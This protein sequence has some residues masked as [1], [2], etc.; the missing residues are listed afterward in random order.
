VLWRIFA[1]V[2]LI[3]LALGSWYLTRPQALTAR[4]ARPKPREQP[5]Y[6]L[7]GTLLT[8]YSV[9]GVPAVRIAAERI[10]QIPGGAD[11]QLKNVRLDYD[12]GNN[13]LWVMVGQQAR[14]IDSGRLI[15]VSGD[16]HLRGLTR[17]REGP[18][19]IRTEKLQ[20]DTQ[21]AVAHTEE[22]VH[23]EFAHHTLTAQ[24]MT[25]RLNEQVMR[26]ESRVNGQFKFV[27]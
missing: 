9:D 25:A 1:I 11:V 23:I 2:A 4:A 10:D 22:A 3:S 14:V 18:A 20:Y 5:A 21:K 19:V 13:Q 8:D 16:V 6:Y 15:E 26:L 12:A 17:G 24:G 27:R 7:T